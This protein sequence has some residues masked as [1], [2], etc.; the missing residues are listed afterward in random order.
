MM[1]DK[2]IEMT[3]FNILNETRP[4]YPWMV[5]R[6]RKHVGLLQDLRSH[7]LTSNHSLSQSF[8]WPLKGAI[9][10]SNTSHQRLTESLRLSLTEEVSSVPLDPDSTEVQGP[11]TET[12]LHTVL[13]CLP[14]A[15]TADTHCKV[16]NVPKLALPNSACPR[17]H[18]VIFTGDGDTPE[19]RSAGTWMCALVILADI[20]DRWV[21]TYT[22][23]N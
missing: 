11:V 5:S 21:T 9:P 3:D 18:P 12:W 2:Q 13:L 23:Q 10:G 14:S 7:D 8:A 15:S 17:L 1:C 6:M 4:L 22:S 19:L 20:K 16:E